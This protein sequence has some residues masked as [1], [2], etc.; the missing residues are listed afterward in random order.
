M[1]TKYHDIVE[2]SFQSFAKE[3]ELKV[4]DGWAIDKSNPGDV[5]GMYGGTFT[6]TLSRNY[7]TVDRFR[8]SAAATQDAPK[9]SPAES[10]ARARQA[11]ASKGGNKG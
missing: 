4:L 7:E 8:K 3:L 9:L 2:T 6:V 5:I 10:L 11:R 1:Q